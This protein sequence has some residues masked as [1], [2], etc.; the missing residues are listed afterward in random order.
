MGIS[1]SAL[2]N[3]YAISQRATFPAKHKCPYYNYHVTLPALKN[4]P[5]P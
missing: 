3:M 4:L 5:L 1:T 2:P